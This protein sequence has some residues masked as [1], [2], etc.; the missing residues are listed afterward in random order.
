MISFCF[1]SLIKLS[2]TNTLNKP[3]LTLL[4]RLEEVHVRCTIIAYAFFLLLLLQ[5][6]FSYLTFADPSR[7]SRYCK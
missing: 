3:P 5:L 4:M 6:Q 7:R 2:G 1:L